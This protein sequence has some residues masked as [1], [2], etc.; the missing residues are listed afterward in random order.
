MRSPFAPG[1]TISVQD[2][3]DLID[4]ALLKPELTPGEVADTTRAL[5][6]RRIWSVCV[7]PSDVAL[8]KQTIAEV[9][10]NDRLIDVVT[11]FYAG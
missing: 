1:S 8:A 10:A 4:H 6:A 9:E 2:V 11:R 7:R 3:A 5:A